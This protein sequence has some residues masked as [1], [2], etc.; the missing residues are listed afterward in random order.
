MGTTW[1]LQ[2]VLGFIVPYYLNERDQHVSLTFSLLCQSKSFLDEQEKHP[3]CRGRQKAEC[4]EGNWDGEIW[5]EFV[6]V[7]YVP[8]VSVH[9]T[10]WQFKRGELEK[11]DRVRVRTCHFHH[12]LPLLSSCFYILFIPLFSLTFIWNWD[13]IES[14]LFPSLTS[15]GDIP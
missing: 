3:N 4:E 8:V 6:Y 12:L 2:T 5:A 13:E 14:D 7:Q 11:L 9:S 1:N 10:I 15:S